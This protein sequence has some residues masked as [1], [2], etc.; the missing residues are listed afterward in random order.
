MPCFIDRRDGSRQYLDL[1]QDRGI[2]ALMSTLQYGD[3][4]FV[5]NGPKG[6]VKVGVE[7]KTTT[8]FRDSFDS[9]RLVSQ[10]AGMLPMYDHTLL[11]VVGPDVH[12]GHAFTFW[13]QAGVLLHHA[14][15]EQAA[16][17]WLAALW[18]WWQKP[19]SKHS[20]LKGLE[21][22]RQGKDESLIPV[23]PS[24]TRMWAA[25]LPGIG[26]ELSGRI[27]KRFNAPVD[28]VAVPTSKWAVPG[29]G[30]KKLSAISKAIR[31]FK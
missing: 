18:R 11:L 15:D 14:T 25:C 2:P 5:G 30:P 22:P 24:L 7:V 16:A 29:L 9:K 13:F 28:L 27:A 20:S 3:V 6:K 26:W 1:L 19:W 31:G 23:D 10:L 12:P 8:D 4:S 17:D 21:L